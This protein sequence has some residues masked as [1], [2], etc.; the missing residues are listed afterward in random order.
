MRTIC[1]CSKYIKSSKSER[2]VK[3]TYIVK[4]SE[5]E[6]GKVTVMNVYTKRY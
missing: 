2:I 5:T 3:N 6:D 4:G 1:D